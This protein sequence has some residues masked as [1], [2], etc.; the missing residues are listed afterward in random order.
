MYVCVGV[1]QRGRLFFI[2]ERLPHV[3]IVNVLNIKEREI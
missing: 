2:H 1:T 3:I